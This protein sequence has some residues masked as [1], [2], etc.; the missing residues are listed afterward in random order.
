MNSTLEAIAG[1][2]AEDQLDAAA[3]RLKEVD[4][5]GD[6][7][8]EKL[9]LEGR[10]C[11]KQGDWDAA[12]LRYAEALEVESDH[13]EA[14]FRLAYLNDLHGED[15]KAMELY[16]QCL[17]ESP[18]HINAMLNLAILYE[19][20]AR[21][22]EACDLVEMVVDQY[23]NHKRARAYLTDLRSSLTMFYD[24]DRE[25]ARSKRDAI[26]DMSISEFELSV[27]SRNCLKQMNIN[28]IGDLLRITEPKLL[29]YKNFGETSLNEIKAMLA[30]KGMHLGQ[31]L[32]E[33]ARVP[34]PGGPAPGVAP[35]VSAG[36]PNMLNRS[37]AELE[38]SVRSR[39]CLQRLGVATIGELTQKSDAELL[40]T[41]NFGMTSLAEIRRRLS[42]LGL[43]LRE[44]G[45]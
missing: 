36:D 10:L 17:D 1:M 23:P 34:G 38:L 39:K 37:V 3:T 20:Q 18:M 5:R 9:Y 42:E 22:Q 11:E 19:D 40:A 26:L 44:T 45:R 6:Y 25:A 14:I 16:E 4:G 31:A 2:I 35:M 41:K 33:P 12:M 30:S 7:A 43:S 27:R 24:E 15:E 29:A 13:C 28:T 21:Y 8:S 32:E